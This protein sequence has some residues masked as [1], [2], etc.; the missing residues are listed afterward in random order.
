MTGN[1]IFR[2]VADDAFTLYI[3]GEYGSTGSALSEEI[4]EASAGASD[5]NHYI[6]NHTTAIGQ[7]KALVGGKYYYMVAYHVNWIGTGYFK[8]SVE[9]PNTDATLIKKRY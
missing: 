4:F 8:I 1:Y 7:E 3:S 2:G 5:E 6:S 9:V